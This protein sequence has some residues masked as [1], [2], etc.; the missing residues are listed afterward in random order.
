MPEFF[1][2]AVACRIT[3]GA[4][5]TSRL[6]SQARWFSQYRPSCSYL[7]H[8]L[9][10]VSVQIFVLH[11]QDVVRRVAREVQ[12]RVDVIR[13]PEPRVKI[14]LQKRFEAHVGR[15]QVSQS[16][17]E[18]VVAAHHVPPVANEVQNAVPF[19]GAVRTRAL[20]VLHVP[21]GR[22]AST[23]YGRWCEGLVALEGSEFVVE[24]VIASV[25][26]VL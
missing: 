3:N 17:A 22:C 7:E 18:V 26:A 14:G 25:G 21:H 10:R 1:V 5:Q 19:R 15:V 13:P 16:Q 20:I 9:E 8:R 6:Q 12:V 24:V 23:R 11:R 4:A 2:G